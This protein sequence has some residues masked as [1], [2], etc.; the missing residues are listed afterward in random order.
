MWPF[1]KKILEPKF[2]VEEEVY[3]DWSSVP[4]QFIKERF[5][6]DGSWRYRLSYQGLIKEKELKKIFRK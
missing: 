6:T 1:K 4:N 5:Y 2:E 3:L